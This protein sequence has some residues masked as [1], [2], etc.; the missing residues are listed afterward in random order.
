M[1]LIHTRVCRS[2]GKLFPPDPAFFF[3]F[4]N[5]TATPEIYPLPLHDALP[6]FSRGRRR[7]SARRHRRWRRVCSIAAGLTTQRWLRHSI[8]LRLGL[9]SCAHLAAR[10][11]FLNW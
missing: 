10:K 11:H 5:D 8:F 9:R 4:F 3:F 6:I 7:I 1:T 2:F